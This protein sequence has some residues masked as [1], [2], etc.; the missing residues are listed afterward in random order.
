MEQHSAWI[1]GSSGGVTRAPSS[2]VEKHPY[3]AEKRIDEGISEGQKKF[4]RDYN[5]MRNKLV[6]AGLM[7]KR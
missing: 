3:I 2:P 6:E 4:L 1:V 7:E 5:S